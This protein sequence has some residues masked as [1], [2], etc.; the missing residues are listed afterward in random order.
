MASPTKDQAAITGVGYTRIS[1]SSG[2]SVAALAY[3]ACTNAIRDAGLS[4]QD[5][6]GILS[7]SWA[8]D[9]IPV[10]EVQTGLGMRQSQWHEDILGGGPQCCSIIG[11]AAMAVA[12]GLCKHVLCYRA[13]NGRT[14]LRMGR[15]G[16]GAV[17]RQGA[18]VYAGRDQWTAPF[19]F[20]GPPQRNAMM[21]RKHM[22]RYGTTHEQLGQVAM[23]LRDN[24]VKNERAVMRT[25]LTM[26]DYLNSRWI[27]EPLRLFDCCQETDGGCA[28]I[29]SRADQAKDMLHPPVYVIAFAQGGGPAMS[30]GMDKYDDFTAMF[31]KYIA[32]GLFNR[33]GVTVDDVDFAEIYD[34]FTFAVICQLEDFGFCQKGEGGPFVAEGNIALTG[35]LPVGTHGGLLSEGYIHGMNNV[36]EAVGQLRG[37]AGARQVRG[38]RIGLVSGFASNMGS[39]LLLST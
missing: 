25:P 4:S 39:A 30:G 29:V 27:A 36:A 22:A 9:S 19:G 21:T 28:V 2:V 32:P 14:G 12:S 23:T 10:R 38:A 3:E 13:L 11:Q 33:G 7:Y 1:R 16:T 17:G 5:V 6:D 31:P 20:A 26:E 18:R 34:A 15:L 8:G 35:K 24:A 37:A